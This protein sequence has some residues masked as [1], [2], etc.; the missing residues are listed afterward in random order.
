MTRK[1]LILLFFLIT[2]LAESQNLE[3]KTNVIDAITLSNEERKPLLIF[4]TAVNVP[5]NLQNEVFKTSEFEKWSRRNVILVKLDLS[6]SAVSNEVK[7]Q[8]IKL[9][10]A[11]GVAALPEICYATGSIRNG[12]TAFNLLG[13]IPYS[14]NGVKSFITDSNLILNPE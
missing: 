4:F 9:K 14:S 13:R 3:W 7:E 1:L 5:E 6:D 8:N 10:N 11:F 12:K 2:C